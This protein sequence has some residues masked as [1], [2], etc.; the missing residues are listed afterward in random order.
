M[1]PSVAD[2]L[3][4]MDIFTLG[5]QGL[6]LA[7]YVEELT[8]EAIDLVIDIRETAWSHKPGFSKTPLAAGLERAGIEYI[9]LKS[10]GNPASNRKT[11]KTIEECLSR[12]KQHLRKQ[13]RCVG[14]LVT[15]IETARRRNRKVCLTCF[16]RSPAECH[17]SV[18]IKELVRH[19]ESLSAI[20]LP[21]ERADQRPVAGTIGQQW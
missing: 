8:S 21:I 10:A 19:V 4:P 18:L 5:Y 6:S 12:Y 17:R 2:S 7:A 13:P 20:H 16:E 1:W 11:A 15:I 3:P 9:H 14:E